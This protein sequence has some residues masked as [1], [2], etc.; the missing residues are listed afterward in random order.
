MDRAAKAI[1]DRVYN[2]E[3]RER[4][5]L[6]A[7][8]WRAKN[9]EKVKRYRQDWHLR[10]KYGIGLDEYEKRL[11][12]QGGVCA[13]CSLPGEDTL[14]V[15]HDHKTG[16]VRALLC[17]LCNIGLGAFADDPARLERAMGY[18]KEHACACI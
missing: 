4:K 16:A 10:K 3:H 5:A 17:H 14:D 7:A 6:R 11:A 1:Y 12:D 18:L 8:V 15:D 13:I 2:Q 9:R